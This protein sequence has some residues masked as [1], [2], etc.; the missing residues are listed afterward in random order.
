VSFL[1][2]TNAMSEPTRATPDPAF[3]AWFA[4]VDTE[5]IFISTLTIGEIRRGLARLPD[6]RRREQVERLQASLLHRFA[7]QIIPVDVAVAE[8][9]GGLSAALR[10]QGRV[11]GAVDELIAATA[12]DRNLTLVTRNRRHFEPT[13]CALLSPWSDPTA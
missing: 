11:I 5:D 13:G 9:W 7:D 8:T 10:A 12:I 2:D 1:L 4:K 6:G 3:Q